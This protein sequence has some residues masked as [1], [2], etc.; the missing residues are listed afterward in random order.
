MNQINLMHIGDVRRTVRSIP[1]THLGTC[2]DHANQSRISRAD[3]ADRL[4]DAFGKER[5]TIANAF[6]Q[7]QIGVLRITGELRFDNVSDVLPVFLTMRN[8]QID[9]LV[10]VR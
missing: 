1:K 2:D 8:E 3:A 10:L 6:D 9:A 7:N 5:W 4:M